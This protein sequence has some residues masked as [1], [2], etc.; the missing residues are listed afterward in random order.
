M[1]RIVRPQR[2]KKF[3]RGSDYIGLQQPEQTE[4]FVI[5]LR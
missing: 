3:M 2:M 5:D 1:D 4:V